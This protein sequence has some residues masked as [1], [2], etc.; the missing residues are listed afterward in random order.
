[1]H[2]NSH[3][4]GVGGSVKR[5][6][7]LAGRVAESLDCGFVGGS[8]K[9]LD[10][11]RVRRIERWEEGTHHTAESE[12][13]RCDEVHIHSQIHMLMLMTTDTQGVDKDARCHL[14]THCHALR[15]PREMRMGL[16]TLRQEAVLR[17][18]IISASISLQW[19]WTL[20]LRFSDAEVVSGG[21]HNSGGVV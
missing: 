11:K 19:L 8:L 7:V 12:R 2:T 21:S 13:R 4:I 3:G 6:S 15:R 9:D 16:G 18:R 14:R 10:L 17:S 5:L 20:G 1:M